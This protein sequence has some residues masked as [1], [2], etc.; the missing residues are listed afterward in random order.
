MRLPIDLEP[1]SLNFEGGALQLRIGAAEVRRVKIFRFRRNPEAVQSL[2]A[3]LAHFKAI[4][5]TP[6]R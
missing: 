4:G 5:E 2:E 1:K 3:F 6:D